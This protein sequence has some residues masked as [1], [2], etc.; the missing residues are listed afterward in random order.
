MCIGLYRFMRLINMGGPK[1]YL[2][3]MRKLDRFSEGAARGEKATM[4]GFG[5]L[6]GLGLRCEGISSATVRLNR[7]SGEIAM[8]KFQFALPEVCL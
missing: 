7:S 6:Y 1:R 3:G 4:F 2:I 5:R 8:P